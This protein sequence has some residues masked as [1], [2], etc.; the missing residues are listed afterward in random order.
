MKVIVKEIKKASFYLWGG[1]PILSTDY[2][3]EIYV[4]NILEKTFYD[5]DSIEKYIEYL[6]EKKKDYQK[7]IKEIEI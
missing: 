1:K 4:D 2:S 3:Y 5:E 7:V 6:E